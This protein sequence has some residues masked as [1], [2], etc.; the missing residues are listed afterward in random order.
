MYFNN[1]GKEERTYDA[2]VVGSGMSGGWAAKE[3][4]ESGLKTL[5]LERGRDVKH[6]D[7]PTAN[8]ATW[9]FKNR[10]GLT[11]KEK[12]EYYVQ[13]R[14]YI[15][16]EPHKH[17]LVKDVDHPYTE[18]KPFDWIRGYHT[19]GRSLIWAR[20]SYRWSPLDFESNARD[21]VGVD[22]PIRYEDLAPWYDYVEA[23]VG[24][25]GKAE[26]LPQ[27]PDSKFL[28]PM[29]LNCLE[30]KV[31]TG[32]EKN[33]KHRMLTIGRCAHATQMV[34]GRGKCQFRNKCYR[35]CPYG[36]YFSSVSGTLPLA[37]NTGN[38]TLR[39]HS[40]VHSVI[41][42][43]QTQRAKGVRVIDAETGEKLEF[44][45]KGVLFLCA[46]AFGSAL[47]LMNSKSDRF[48]NGMGNDSG[49]LGH[50]VMD[51]HFRLGARGVS[52]EFQ[53]RYYKGNRPNGIYIP[54]FRNINK[55]TEQKDFLR[56]YGYQGG[57]SRH[58]WQHFV[59]ELQM[60]KPLNLKAVAPG[61]WQFGINAF[62]EM[63][64][65]HDNYITLNEEKLDKHGMPTLSMHVEIK[66]N[67]IAMRKDMKVQAAE[68]LD[69]AGL[70]DI[71]MYE[72]DYNPGLGIHEM[73]TARMG[74]DPK[75]SVLNGFNQVH[76]VQNVF[77]T[78]G[79]CMTSSACQNP[80]LTYMAL[81]ARA[82]N[83]AVDLLKKK[84]LG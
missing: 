18:V 28:P 54:R 47:I 5:I 60:G 21:G 79:A 66:E 7:Y 71:E 82:A 9:E 39:P 50:N 76:S 32:I 72:D 19:G 44:F 80:S 12:E 58:G 22:W 10:G 30:E 26:N 75:T 49:E 6:G 13:D 1:K 43:D 46:S 68:M 69:A 83:H 77:V 36:G 73:G 45:T 35:G 84:E 14:S 34:E 48:P 3:L 4:A 74:R 24:V 2:I 56:G 63:L 42:D 23:V 16:S 20:Q 81:T 29:D 40:I 37:Y 38:A 62:G 31:K 55:E 57:A 59:K 41:Y 33:F 51:H 78:D 65:D 70:K 11:R 53:D 25:S 61:Q 64:P 17:W 52:D 67:E 8:M 27:L 15:F